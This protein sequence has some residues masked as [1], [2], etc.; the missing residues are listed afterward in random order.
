MG[1]LRQRLLFQTDGSPTPRAGCGQP[2]RKTDSGGNKDNHD[3]YGWNYRDQVQKPTSAHKSYTSVSHTRSDGQQQIEVRDYDDPS[4]DD[5]VITYVV[6]TDGGWAESSATP[7]PEVEQPAPEGTATGGGPRGGAFYRVVCGGMVCTYTAL[8][9]QDVVVSFGPI[10]VNP[11]NLGNEGAGS[12][13][14]GPRVGPRAVTDPDP[15]NLG[16]GAG[17]RRPVGRGCGGGMVRC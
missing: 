5:V 9:R 10:Q 4:M 6:G 14:A 2:R 17:S 11:G 16:V 3:R 1:E 7:I 15:E 12:P 13:E 8:S